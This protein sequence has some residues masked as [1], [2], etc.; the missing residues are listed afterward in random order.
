MTVKKLFIFTS[1]TKGF[2]LDYT[3]TSR[4]V[5]QAHVKDHPHQ[6]AKQETILGATLI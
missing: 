5:A 6:E 3:L 4:G 1:Q 2:F